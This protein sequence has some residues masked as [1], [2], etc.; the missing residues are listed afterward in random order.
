[1]SRTISE[2][3]WCN[4]YW[5]HFERK[6]SNGYVDKEVFVSDGGHVKVEKHWLGGLFTTTKEYDTRGNLPGSVC[7]EL[8]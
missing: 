5:R 6:D 4:P 7:N 8:A 2:T 1:M 3:N